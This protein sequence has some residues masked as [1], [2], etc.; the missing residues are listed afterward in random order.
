MQAE[1]TED[2]TAKRFSLKLL[3]HILALFLLSAAALLAEEPGALE[4]PPRISGPD[5]KRT[6]SLYHIL[7]Q[8]LS[9]ADSSGQAQSASPS[10]EQKFLSNEKDRDSEK[11]DLAPKHSPHSS[12]L[13][14]FFSEKFS[15][16]FSREDKKK[17]DRRGPSYNESQS[18]KKPQKILQGAIERSEP[19]E[20]ISQDGIELEYSEMGASVPESPKRL[21]LASSPR[22]D[23]PR[24][25]QGLYLS[26]HTANTPTRYETL[27]RSAHSRGMNALVVDVQPKFPEKRFF[28]SAKAK[29]F[30]LVSRIVV[31]KGGLKRYPPSPTHLEKIYTLVRKSAEEG[32][33]EVQLDYIRFADKRRFKGLTLQKRYR[34]IENIL[35]EVKQQIEPYEIPWGADL[36]GRV[37]FNRNDRIGQKMELFAAY[38]DTIY[39]ML[40]PSHFY[41]QP[42][43]IKNPYGTVRDGIQNSIKKVKKQARIIAYIQAFR[44]SIAPS[45]L[46]FVDYIYKQLKA[47]AQAGGSGYIAWNA[48]NQYA[49]FFKALD[50]LNQL[51]KAA[52]R[53]VLG[54]NKFKKS[55]DSKMS[56]ATEILKLINQKTR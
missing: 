8:G 54:K 37:S 55:Y 21:G 26:A 38:A 33:N 6:E 10:Q 2:R 19:T 11:R 1:K 23:M 24:Y 42:R 16:S 18:I 15:E 28:Q 40:Y 9:E 36:F 27:L 46:S 4:E 53:D 34:C 29:G 17:K 30:H 41:G 32:F 13:K 51:H 7:K 56:P 52:R 20:R 31:F 43:R 44:M 47:V 50:K 35:R 39:P 49:Y 3:I 5:F 25:Y 45:K 12:S 22:L 14:E 48:R